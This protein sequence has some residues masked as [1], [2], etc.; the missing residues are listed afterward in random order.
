M[1]EEEIYIEES[2][3]HKVKI[4]IVVLLV[5]LSVFFIIFLVLKNKYTLTLD[6]VTIEAGDKLS[7]D[8]AF[9]VKNDVVDGSDYK[10]YLSDVPVDSEGRVTTVGEYDYKVKY[11]NITKEGVLVVEDTTVP[12]VEVTDLTIG[13]KEDY[14]ISDFIV[15]CVDYSKPCN[16]TYKKESDSNLQNK[17]GLYEFDIV[18]TDQVGNKV[19]KGIRLIVK[20]DYNSA[21]I[22]KSDLN[23]HHIDPDYDDWN[24]EMILTYSKGVDENHLDHDD[25][26]TYLLDL[27]SDDLSMYIPVEK[28]MYSIEETEIIFVYNKYDYI[29]GFALRVKLSNG[30]YIYLSK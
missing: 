25:R 18:I 24:N 21:D 4:T 9:Y 20:K 29:I 13:V 2:N 17:A 6:K 11:K 8:V 27:L 7:K 22:K 15:S 16:V 1:I 14:D 10:L 28:S 3:P 30:E 12:D 23:I 5:L 26:Y 19:T